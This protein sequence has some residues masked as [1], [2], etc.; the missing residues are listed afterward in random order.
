MDQVLAEAPVESFDAQELRKYLQFG[1][2]GALSGFGCKFGCITTS[3][4]VTGVDDYLIH[5][6]S[7][8]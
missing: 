2:G 5:G 7:A 3:L 4:S 8:F 6:F 1:S